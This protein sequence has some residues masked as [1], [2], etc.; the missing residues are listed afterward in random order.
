[1]ANK[2]TK[3][4]HKSLQVS[5]ENK[6]RLSFEEALGL[7][8]QDSAIKKAYESGEGDWVEALNTDVRAFHQLVDNLAEDLSR[9]TGKKWCERLN[10]V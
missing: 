2:L 7:L 8:L 10:F 6:Q 9:I 3:R 4:I 5:V 1:M